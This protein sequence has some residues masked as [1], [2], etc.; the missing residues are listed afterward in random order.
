MHVGKGPLAQENQFD[1][2]R[3]T[4]TRVGGHPAGIPSFPAC[5]TDP[6]ECGEGWPDSALVA[7]IRG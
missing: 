3:Q 7:G 6:H 5:W 2:G 4:P 1:D